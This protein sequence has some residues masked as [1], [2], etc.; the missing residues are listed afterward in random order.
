MCVGVKGKLMEAQRWR[1]I[2][3]RVDFFFGSRGEEKTKTGIAGLVSEHASP[4]VGPEYFRAGKVIAHSETISFGPSQ[5]YEHYSFLHSS[6]STY[7]PMSVMQNELRI[8]NSVQRLRC[9]GGPLGLEL[10]HYP[11]HPFSV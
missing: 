1:T 2:D 10:A 8:F 11:A 5:H 3:G 6:S 4:L 7:Y 9:R